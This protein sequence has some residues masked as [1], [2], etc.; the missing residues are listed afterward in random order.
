MRGLNCVCGDRQEVTSLRCEFKLN[1][2]KSK[3]QIVRLDKQS[4]PLPGEAVGM[5]RDVRNRLR[6]TWQE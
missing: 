1:A 6:P 5:L 2:G 3:L 4:L